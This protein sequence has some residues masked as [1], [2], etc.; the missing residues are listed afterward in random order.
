MNKKFFFPLC[1]LMSVC[2]MTFTSCSSEDDVIDVVADNDAAIFN[3]TDTESPFASVEFT[4]SGMYILTQR[5]DVV[6][7][8][9]WPKSWKISAAQSELS[10]RGCWPK[11]WKISAAKSVDE[12]DL[13]S[14]EYTKNGNVYTLEDF[15]SITVV[16]K[17]NTVVDLEMK[18]EDGETYTFSAQIVE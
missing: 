11:S 10:T 15:G 8:T 16:K 13:I 4:E 5:T 18:A 14:G 7:S 3:I 2:C 17:G 6:A 1:M 12:S 9:C